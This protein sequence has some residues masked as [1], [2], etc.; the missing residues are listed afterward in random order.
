MIVVHVDDEFAGV[1]FELLRDSKADA[2]QRLA[3][4][5]GPILSSSGLPKTI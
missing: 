3:C 2:L 1:V 4:A 5:P